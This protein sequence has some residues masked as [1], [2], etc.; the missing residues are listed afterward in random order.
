[1]KCEECS[2]GGV[3]S[4]RCVGVHVKNMKCEWWR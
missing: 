3:M 1:M 2:G 4:V